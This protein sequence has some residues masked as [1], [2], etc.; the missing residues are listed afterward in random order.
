MTDVLKVDVWSDV[1]CPWCYIGKRR[2]AEGVRRYTEAGGD[3][4]LPR[5]LARLVV[6]VTDGLF[7]ADQLGEGPGDDLVDLFVDVLD[8]VVAQREAELGGRVVR[9]RRL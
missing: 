1:A 5:T 2:F 4:E 9:G 8:E 3:R 7:L 6:V